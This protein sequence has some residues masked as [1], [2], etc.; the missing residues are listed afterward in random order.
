MV[1]KARKNKANARQSK[2]MAK[3][4]VSEVKRTPFADAGRIAGR[5]LAQLIHP[6]LAGLGSSA[7]SFIGSGIGKI[8]G[9]GAYAMTNSLWNVSQQCPAMHSSDES[10]VFRHREYICD[11][12]GTTAFTLSEFPINPGLSITF[13][14]LS[15]IAQN[16]QQYRFKGLVFEYR[17]TSATA[18]VSGTNTAMGAVMLAAQYRS[19]APDFLD[20]Q[21]L[22]NEMWSV[23][24]KPS[25]NV[26]LPV[27]CAPQ[28]TPLRF[29]YIRTGSL[30]ANQDIKFYDLA[31]LAVAVQGSQATNTIGEL[32]VS[33]E[34]EL[35]KP[36]VSGSLEL[37]GESF[38][39]DRSGAVAASPYGT[40]ANST[41]N[42]MGVTIS[43][44]DLVLPRGTNGVYYITI[45]WFGGAAA[46]VQ[47]AIT[48]TN[49][50][51]ISVSSNN[52]QDSFTNPSGNVGTSFLV[53]KADPNVTGTVNLGLAGVYPV[54][55]RCVV[56]VHQANGAITS[57]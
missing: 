9:S 5:S 20:K 19:D 21:S 45:F 15:T 46:C 31:N 2:K 27:E 11:I 32:W 40:A 18:L 10:V 43:A 4:I 7:G 30:S 50:T 44:T 57:S 1:R 34:V 39:T 42:S 25:E 16:F 29:S 6:A 12:S 51:Y 53:R 17:S 36:S 38:V 37:A 22:L 23:D 28:E 47:P 41:F 52:R 3:A 54:G 33:Y 24:C 55:A 35:K 13:P 56:Q 8:F 26:F 49:L 48:L 14:Y